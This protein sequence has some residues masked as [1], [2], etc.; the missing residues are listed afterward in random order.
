MILRNESLAIRRSWMIWDGSGA[1]AM[2][3]EATI[4]T[5]VTGQSR[6]DRF[7]VERSIRSASVEARRIFHGGVAAFLDRPERLRDGLSRGNYHIAWG[8]G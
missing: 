3:R 1:A 5:A 4:V 6:P 8:R 7:Y 2:S